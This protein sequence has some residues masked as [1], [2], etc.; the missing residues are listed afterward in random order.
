ML[1]APPPRSSRR[2]PPRS[3][4]RSPAPIHARS[5]HRRAS[6]AFAS[7]P[8]SFG[9]PPRSGAHAEHLATTTACGL[10]CGG[11]GKGGVKGG[12]PPGDSLGAS[13]SPEILRRFCSR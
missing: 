5:L 6:E 2:S 1:T 13:D 10:S 9:A 7:C 4:R 12:A 3:S 11:G 8:A